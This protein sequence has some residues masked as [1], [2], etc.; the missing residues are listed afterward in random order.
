MF[1]DPRH[2]EQVSVIVDSGTL[3]SAAIRIGTSQPAL[4]RMI[5]TLEGR[6]DAE[7]FER[8]RRPLRATPLGL[9]LANQG[10]AIRVARERAAE[11]VEVGA[12][13]SFGVLKIGAPPFLCDRLV[14]ETIYD[15]LSTRQAVRIDLFPDYFPGLHER[16]FLN[17]IDIII[18]P[19]KAADPG[20]S[21]LAFEPLFG[22]KNVL[23][24]RAGHPLLSG[25]INSRA[26]ED[27]VWVGHSDRSKLRNDMET[28]LR[29]MGVANLRFAFQS[30]SAGAVIE[31]LK[32]SD[33]LTVLPNYAL[34]SD[35][36]D[37][38][39]VLPVHL[40]TAEQTIAMMTRATRDETKLMREFKE[41]L[42]A[43]V[44]ERY[45]S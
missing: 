21:E 12:R 45:A 42:R 23:V 25:K 29:L 22:D 35:G 15:F 30:E 40:P 3:Y 41:H 28:A 18:G 27:V 33:A 7:L 26:L 13:G 8:N 6:L 5:R 16:L 34:R 36:N 2:L 32:H 4:S 17:Q 24:G 9:E 31:F 1:I 37:G 11:M 10:R 19:A 20:L 44:A 43:H 14:A 39:A 38:L